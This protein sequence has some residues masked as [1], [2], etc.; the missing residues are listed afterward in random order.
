VSA[1]GSIPLLAVLGGNIFWFKSRN[2]RTNIQ[3]IDVDRSPAS[4]TFGFCV[5]GRKGTTVSAATSF[6]F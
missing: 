2:V 1:P 4:S 5:G 3:V 6:L